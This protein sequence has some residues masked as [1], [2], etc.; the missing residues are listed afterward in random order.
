MPATRVG[1]NATHLRRATKTITYANPGTGAAATTTTIFTVTNEIL[2][3]QIVPFCTTDLTETA[4][5]PTLALGVVGGAT[6]FIAATTAT[7]IDAQEFWVDTAPDAGGVR[8]PSQLELIAI[9]GNITCVVGG[10]NNIDAGVIRYDLYWRPL[11][12]DGNA[13]AA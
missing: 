5:T 12:S 13:V 3:M 6:I 2:V 8:V 4:G 9:T 10:T 7:A 11:S 1:S